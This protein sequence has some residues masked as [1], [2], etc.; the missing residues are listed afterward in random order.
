MLAE[1]IAVKIYVRTIGSMIYIIY[2][3][4]CRGNSKH[5][6][7]ANPYFNHISMD[8][9]KPEIMPTFMLAFILYFLCSLNWL[10]AEVISNI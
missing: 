3:R 5:Y 2:F 10:Y 6:M 4:R 9:Y 8:N 1:I 7:S